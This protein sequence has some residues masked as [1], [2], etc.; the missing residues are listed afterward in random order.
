MEFPVSVD[1]YSLAASYVI[2]VRKKVSVNL[3][4]FCKQII[5]AV[6]SNA[7]YN[8]IN[9]SFIG[10]EGWSGRRCLFTV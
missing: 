5:D 4:H 9:C 2:F 6:G 10:L 8:S 1:F 3:L 7:L